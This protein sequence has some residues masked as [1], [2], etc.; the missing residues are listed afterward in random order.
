MMSSM[1][2]SRAKNQSIQREDEVKIRLATIETE[3]QL[4]DQ[5]VNEQPES[6]IYHRWAWKNVIE[7]SFHWRTF[8]LVAEDA[9]EPQRFRGILPLA[10]Q[11]S[12]MFGSFLTSLPFLNAGGIVA[13]SVD[14]KEQLLTRAVEI[15]KEVGVDYVELRYRTE[16]HLD[17]PVKTHKVAMVRPVT[18]S[19]EQMWATLPHKVRTDIRKGTSSGL[20]AE[21]ACEA[22][23]DEFYD[24]FAVNMRDL[25]TP[26]YGRRF[27]S[28]ILKSFPDD[29]HICVVRYQGRPIAASF[30]LGYRGTLEAVWSSSLYKYS[31]LRPN[32]FLYWKILCFAGQQGYRF[33]DFGR[34]SVGSGTYRFKKQWGTEDV[35]LYW[36]YWVP[37][38]APLPEV[39]RENPR[40]RRAISLWQRFPVSLTKIV[41]P[42]I[43]KRLP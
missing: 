18:V 41:G 34:S 22:L 24:V 42:S 39:N 30:L 14:A 1:D 16:P 6:T 27:F 2:E 8:Y 15:A 43:V 35:P 36:A 7:N 10:W 19:E 38:G 33:F 17:I 32:M 26:V 23:L 29:T 31:S 9:A 13:D 3:G 5:F 12:W 37:D 11:K 21:F 20:V 4:W 25:G 40:Y 28:E